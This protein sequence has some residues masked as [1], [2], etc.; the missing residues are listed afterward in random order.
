MAGQ[1]KVRPT[2]KFLPVDKK[3]IVESQVQVLTNVPRVH[4][5]N[6]DENVVQFKIK[7][8]DKEKHKIRVSFDLVYDPKDTKNVPFFV[9]H[10]HANSDSHEVR[11]EEL[12]RINLQIKA[13]SDEIYA[14]HKIGGINDYVVMGDFNENVLQNTTTLDR[15]TLK[16]II[17]N[18]G[19]GAKLNDFTLPE[20]LMSKWRGI[21]NRAYN[22]FINPQARKDKKQNLNDS[23][24]C[25]F[26]F[27]LQDSA[28]TENEINSL[29]DQKEKEIKAN[30]LLNKD[31][32]KH[33]TSF[34]DHFKSKLFR[35]GNIIFS[36]GSLL[37]TAGP[38]GV[39]NPEEVF[40]P[41][42]LERKNQ[43]KR[44]L[45]QEIATQK[46]FELLVAVFDPSLKDLPNQLNDH[47]LINTNLDK[48][49]EAMG[50]KNPMELA[51]GLQN[52]LNNWIKC[53]AH[54]DVLEML[55][56]A[57]AQ[58]VTKKLQELANDIQNQVLS[59][60]KGDVIGKFVQVIAQ[61]ESQELTGGYGEINSNALP[62]VEAVDRAQARSSADQIDVTD[63]DFLY[64][65]ID[66]EA[67]KDATT[68][69]EN[70]SDFYAKE[71]NN[72][73]TALPFDEWKR[74]LKQ[75]L[76]N[77]HLKYFVKDLLSPDDARLR[78]ERI[79]ILIQALDSYCGMLQF[80]KNS[81][82]DP[83]PTQRAWVSTIVAI[84]HQIKQDFPGHNLTKLIDVMSYQ[85]LFHVAS[86][87]P[88][89]VQDAEEVPAEFFK[90]LD[91][92][93]ILAEDKRFRLEW[94]KQL[95]AAKK[96][97]MVEWAK[98]SLQQ[99]E[100]LSQ[101]VSTSFKDGREQNAQLQVCKEM[102][103]A[104]HGFITPLVQHDN[105][106]RNPTKAEFEKFEVEFS[107]IAHSQVPLMSQQRSYFSFVANV[108]I[109]LLTAGIAHLIKGAVTKYTTGVAE[110]GFFN[111][112]RRMSLV[113]DI[114]E[115]VL[116]HSICL[117]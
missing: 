46:L 41:E 30:P 36:A 47:A 110:F 62:G 37:P 63:P 35:R 105:S 18:L 89:Y 91:E 71:V 81:G 106:V 14:K 26:Y 13:F 27:T 94:I 111:E 52:V 99:I 69:K 20:G 28:Q 44:I 31:F 77:R 84:N 16:F 117:N 17:G 32:L 113:H 50:K 92:N 85:L 56:P 53:K 116:D 58:S 4:R 3:L 72:N 15:K 66:T 88:T 114:D 75:Y 8:T 19:T 43:G 104:L 82:Q 101:Y 21:L 10:Y 76:K 23:K 60:A 57:K 79:Q 65:Y 87:H 102:T 67:A 80:L 107:A 90:P 40:L 5:L 83:L 95:V 68:N 59:K 9:V 22:L 49:N 108:I 115:Q 109:G 54:T 100:N 103:D 112:T 1:S 98:A 51:Q 86:K 55:L 73:I 78:E 48:L 38:K 96:S 24:D 12:K 74:E 61:L 42:W 39:K 7:E 45:R 70:K 2:H 29:L 34:R 25:I 33:N 64:Y 11:E 6:P 97:P 93:S